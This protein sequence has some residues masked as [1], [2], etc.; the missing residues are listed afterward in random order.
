MASGPRVLFDGAEA[1]GHLL[2]L[3][4]LLPD[5]VVCR[6]DADCRT[7]RV[8]FRLPQGLSMAASGNRDR[9]YPTSLAYTA[10]Y[11]EEH[12]WDGSAYVHKN[13]H[14]L[15]GPIPR[16]SEPVVWDE[17]VPRVS[18]PQTPKPKPRTAWERLL[19]E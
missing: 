6:L 14:G 18:L 5:N 4:K 15:P 2:E 1:V 17:L 8:F 16:P 13:R 19:D 3:N 9:P 11:V 12:F 10:G 7:L